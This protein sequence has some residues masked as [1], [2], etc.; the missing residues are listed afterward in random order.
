MRR[1][2]RDTL[3]AVVEPGLLIG[4]DDELEALAGAVS[5]AG[6][7]AC[8][9]YLEG[10]AGMGKTALV[11]HL[12]GLAAGLGRPVRTGAAVAGRT[13]RPFGPILDALGIELPDALPGSVAASAK[14]TG[15]EPV[16]STGD[17]LFALASDARYRWVDDL[18][19]HLDTLAAATP[20]VVVLDDLH[21]A[22]ASVPMVLRTA[23]RRLAGH[24]ILLVA[25][26]RPVSVDPDAQRVLQQLRGEADVFVRVDPL[27]PDDVN[28]IARR[29]LRCRD[30]GPELSAR[31]EHA[32]GTPLIVHE[33]LADLAALGALVRAADGAIE[34][35]RDAAGPAAAG[36]VGW[37]ER[38]LRRLAEATR[39]YVEAAAVLGAEFERD[40]AVAVAG[41]GSEANAA[42][43]DSAASG[44]CTG[45]GPVAHFA[46]DLVRDAVIGL[47]PPA[48]AASL[49]LAAARELVA[50]GGAAARV[51]AHLEIGD[52]LGAPVDRTELARY[53]AHAGDDAML[54]S[55]AAA[56]GF[57]DRAI[58]RL[59]VDDRRRAEIGLARLGAA[60]SAA[61]CDRAERDGHELL[62][63]PLDAATALRVR[64]WL[65]GAQFLR[66]RTSEAARLYEEAADGLQGT[67]D[68]A[69]CLAMAAMCHL[70]AFDADLRPS[71][72]RALEA[73]DRSGDAV[74]RAVARMAQSR[75]LAFGGRQREARAAAEEAIRIADADPHL[76][77]HRY[78]PHAI[79]AVALLDELDLEGVL[80]TVALGRR[81]ASATGS[82]WAESLYHALA[83]VGLHAA[84]RLDDALSQAEAGLAVAL[85]GGVQLANLWCH[86]V[87]ALV[88]QLQGDHVGAHAAIE[89]G[90]EVLGSGTGQLGFDLLGLAEARELRHGGRVDAATVHLLGVLELAVGI[91]VP[92][93]GL[94]VLPDLLAAAA[95][96]GDADVVARV[97]QFVDGVEEADTLPMLGFARQVCDALRHDT[98]PDASRF[99]A[100]PVSGALV[101]LG[102]AEGLMRRGEHERAAR[103]VRRAER[104]L[105]EHR[106]TGE[107]EASHRRFPDVVRRGRPPRRVVTGWGSLTDTE[108]YVLRRLAAD[109]SNRAIA[110]ASGMSPGPSRPT[111]PASC[112]SSPCRHVVRPP[113][114]RGHGPS[115][116][117]TRRGWAD[118]FPVDFS[119]VVARIVLRSRR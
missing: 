115:E 34:L 63:A 32:R 85:D 90:R 74:S 10:E 35:D 89:A 73:G 43:R 58:E 52:A 48:R 68:G 1:N 105:I 30:L 47:L 57:Y 7:R 101:D 96:D 4:R 67:V 12:A 44:F 69:R 42:V 54:R 87:M 19:G 13:D 33:L 84:G 41:L 106:A 2:G 64:W 75:S 61:Q 27:S 109:E 119:Y 93:T 49:N 71:A 46:H 72:Q 103:V 22:D 23:R 99:T 24:P 104:V 38:R 55:P 28:A 18:C 66:N 9:V 62:G 79:H 102:Y 76:E 111:S 8:L 113:R 45:V 6:T 37:I 100:A 65:G 50:R 110:A 51:A 112:A 39:R 107:I 36:L 82:P 70:L 26:A 80:A 95:A 3:R 56:L 116:P 29:T 14:P 31:L 98:D 88:L 21:W 20:L 94:S 97:S 92:A 59:P 53:L 15:A 60:V 11:E 118:R 91:D 17:A 5:V 108:H 114:W 78:Q 40:L 83:A 77:T 86:S 16:G 117:G 81:R 25:T